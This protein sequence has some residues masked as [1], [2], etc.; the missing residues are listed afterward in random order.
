[1]KALIA[2]M[3]VASVD[4]FCIDKTSSTELSEA[5]NSMYQWYQ[6]ADMCYDYLEDVEK[7][8]AD[9][10][11]RQ[12]R[13]FTRGWTLQELVAPQQIVFFDKGFQELGTK[14]SLAQTIS[15]VTGI[16]RKTLFD[17]TNLRRRSIAKRMSWAAKRQTIRIEDRA[18]LFLG[19]F[20]VNMPLLYGE[21]ENAFIRLQEELLKASDDHTIFAWA[22]SNN[23]QFYVY[24]TR[25]IP[26][27][28][29]DDFK[30]AGFM[31]Q[32]PSKTSISPY[33]MTNKGLIITGTILV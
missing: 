32:V 26:T 23:N 12:S 3:F 19:I 8:R 13:W 27:Q 4:R 14:I 30:D 9:E 24:K 5:I 22:S 16:D 31:I 18:Y 10:F 1:V 7:A 11:I 28:R 25:S 6:N 20:G 21:G 15:R 29:P 17:A 33:I 2:P